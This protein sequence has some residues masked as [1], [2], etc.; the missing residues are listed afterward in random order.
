MLSLH[1][2]LADYGQIFQENV[3]FLVHIISTKSSPSTPS[4]LDHHLDHYHLHIHYYHH[5]Y[6]H[7]HHHPDH[8]HH[9][10]HLLSVDLY[11]GQHI[12]IIIII[13]NI[14]TVITTIVTIITINFPTSSPLISMKGS[15]PFFE[16]N[17]H[18]WSTFCKS[19]D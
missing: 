3:H 19:E 14:I 8:H 7:H 15:I 1:L 4:P 13:S 5:H 12:I 11:E 6:Y 17:L 10:A 18:L 9:V 2:F 16:R